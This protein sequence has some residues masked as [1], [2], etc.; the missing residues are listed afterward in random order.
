MCQKILSR[1]S[2]VISGDC[3]TVTRSQVNNADEA[4]VF[5]PFIF[6]SDK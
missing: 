2:K 3:I 5:M 6:N 1:I 4:A